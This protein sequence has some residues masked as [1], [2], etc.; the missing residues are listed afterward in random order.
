VGRKSR[1]ARGSWPGRSRLQ[2]R[3]TVLVILKGGKKKSSIERIEIVIARGR[4]FG[5]VEVAKKAVFDIGGRAGAMGEGFY[6]KKG[7][8]PG[9]N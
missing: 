3:E 6:L 9:P 7:A 8:D 2:K 4:K 1:R 5:L